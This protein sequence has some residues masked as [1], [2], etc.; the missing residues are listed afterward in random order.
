MSN[1]HA[2]FVASLL[3][4]HEV[5]DS[6][7][8]VFPTPTDDGLAE[9]IKCCT[10]AAT[11]TRKPLSVPIGQAQHQLLLLQPHPDDIALSVGGIL[12]RVL[13]Q[14]AIITVYAN[15][16]NP[17]MAGC[18]RAEDAE[19]AQ[20]LRA[21]LLTLNLPENPSSSPVSNS[22]LVLHT[23]R[24]ATRQFTGAILLA[25][26][27]VARHPDH[28][29]VQRVAADL[30]CGVFWEDVAFWGIY[31]SCVDDRVLLC[32]RADLALDEF[33]LVAVDISRQIEAKAMMLGCYSSQSTDVWRPLRYA[34]TAA[35]EIGAPFSYCERLFIHDRHIREVE[36]VL[37]ASISAAGSLRYGTTDVRTGW[38]TEP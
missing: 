30:G 19:F 9:F 22:D 27:S 28:R 16:H 20:L 24:A 11:R 8:P 4:Q 34:W 3:Q 29:V 32:E 2:E 15:G 33:T 10:S 31:G 37:G 5:S 7:F 25:P 21:D 12:A 13:A 6:T 23:M 36:R 17:E 14:L 18:R 1:R 38:F 26:A 35:R